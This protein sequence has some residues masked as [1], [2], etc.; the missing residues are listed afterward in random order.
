MV[1]FLLALFAGLL[2]Y[3]LIDNF[4]KPLESLHN[5]ASQVTAGNLSVHIDP[6]ATSKEL[7]E[8]AHAFNKMLLSIKNSHK[9]INKKVIQQ[10]HE[11]VKNTQYLKDQQKAIL[12]VL[13][14]VEAEKDRTAVEK[15]KIAAV[16]HSIGDAVFVVDK[17]LKITMINEIAINLCGYGSIHEAIGKKYNLVLKLIYE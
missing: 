15:D 3:L 17:N 11:I 7:D 14:D 1:V 16:L 9:E 10:T 5:F 12:N 2:I 8:L 4:L 13:E 6:I